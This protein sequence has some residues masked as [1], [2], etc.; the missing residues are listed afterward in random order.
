VIIP[1]KEFEL[2]VDTLIPA[3]GQ[4]LNV[5]FVDE[6]LLQSKLGL[7][8][9]LENV[10]IGGDAYRG[11]SFLIK[12]IADGKDVAIK[13]LLKMGIEISGTD[14]LERDKN[15]REQ[16]HQKLSRII[17]GI[18]LK[19]REIENR[20]LDALVDLPMSQ[21]EV[22]LESARCVNCDE[23]CDICITVCPNRANVGYELKPIDKK[24]EKIMVNNGMYTIVPDS[25]FIIEQQ[26]QILNIADLCNECGN[27]TT[28]CPTEGRPFADKPNVALSPESFESMERGYWDKGDHMLC[29]QNDVIYRLDVEEDGYVYSSPSFTIK[30]DK[31]FSVKQVELKDNWIGEISLRT[32]L[33]MHVI[34]KA[35]E[36]VIN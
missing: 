19:T 8:T 7:E 35:I 36:S 22:I 18:K 16:H 10:F 33:N 20:T 25:N 15:S 29:K 32:A 9:R 14:T 11:A 30:L 27:C 28:F 2:P 26:Y 23:I 13:I 24:I 34:K 12:A 1:G 3:F 21:D 17:P 31:K 5:D 4:S 6:E